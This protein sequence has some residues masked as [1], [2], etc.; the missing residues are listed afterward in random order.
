MDKVNFNKFKSPNSKLPDGSKPSE[1]G[2][3][4]TIWNYDADIANY[5]GIDKLPDY[6]IFN[7]IQNY[8]LV[9][10]YEI[11][12]ENQDQKQHFG[13]QLCNSFK[14]SSANI[15]NDGVIDEEELMK[16]F[17]L[18]VKRA[19]E[20]KKAKKTEKTMEVNYPFTVIKKSRNFIDNSTSGFGTSETAGGANVS[21]YYVK[22]NDG[23][24]KQLKEILESKNIKIPADDDYSMYV[25]LNLLNAKYANIDGK[26]KEISEDEVI[27][28]KN[29]LTTNKSVCTKR[30]GVTDALYNLAN[31]K[32]INLSITNPESNVDIVSNDAIIAEKKLDDA[33]N[34][35]AQEDIDYLQVRI[36][37]SE[38]KINNSN[39]IMNDFENKSLVGTKDEFRQKFDD[40]MQA[41][42]SDDV[43]K[44][45][46]LKKEVLSLI[47]E[48]K[49]DEF[50]I[51]EDAAKDNKK[52]KEKLAKTSEELVN[53]KKAIEDDKIIINK[54]IA[55]V[56]EIIKNNGVSNFQQL[57]LLY[58]EPLK[59]NRINPRTNK[60]ASVDYGAND[61]TKTE[62]YKKLTY[63]NST[64]GK[65]K[66][67]DRLAM[68]K[69]NALLGYYLSYE[70]IELENKD[71]LY[72]FI[73]REDKNLIKTGIN[74]T[75]EDFEFGVKLEGDR[76]KVIETD[77][78]KIAT[79]LDLN[80]YKN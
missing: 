2:K 7:N 13:S 24:K 76:L 18:E 5:K 69:L 47:K 29:E 67:Y 8:A 39:K 38:D 48:K 65:M 14:R 73:P 80:Y 79:K 61:K 25:L 58:D 49:Q 17:E 41:K 35:D 50:K 1:G 30:Q 53:L 16:F 4:M 26:V 40:Y 32:T 34:K 12:Y 23:T 57:K 66:V 9:N 37:E 27:A 15:R 70:K 52:A 33:I 60:N 20:A 36:K 43:K 19:E 28:F 62:L 51:Y 6:A 3:E 55:I 68:N 56:N 78:D 77:A 11:V 10:G 42:S 45:S 64:N 63:T 74:L 44:K 75:K 59:L 31:G 22:I 72:D 54:K 46:A 21:V 71:V